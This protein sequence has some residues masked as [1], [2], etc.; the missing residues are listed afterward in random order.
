M[1]YR[2]LREIAAW[3][4]MTAVV[5]GGLLTS[6]PADSKDAVPQPPRLTA[7]VGGCSISAEVK[8]AQKPNEVKIVITADNPSADTKRLD[9]VVSLVRRDFVGSPLSRSMSPSDYREK[10]ERSQMVHFAPTGKHAAVKTL[11]MSIDASPAA[12]K[13]EVIP[14]STP[15]AASKP[16]G[17]PVVIP[18]VAPAS[19]IA[20]GFAQVPSY[21]VRVHTDDT[22]PAA[23]ARFAASIAWSKK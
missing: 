11:T 22:P 5:V 20:P 21:E 12:P 10:V 17:L 15:A 6:R 13:P 7:S 16:A 18:I 2:S 4:V 3:A 8:A 9:V 1:N 14:V 23:I 19:G